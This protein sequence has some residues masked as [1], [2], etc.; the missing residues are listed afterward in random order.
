[1]SGLT[2]IECTPKEYIRSKQ[3]L[4]G[5]IVAIELLIDKM[6]LDT[7]DIA[8]GTSPDWV[9][10]AGTASYMMDDGQM[11]V[12]TQYRSLAEVAKGIAEL[13][14][15]LQMFMNQ[16]NGRAVVLRGRLNY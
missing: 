3:T 8:A 10:N 7:V 15:I 14:K 6:L 13:E 5:R 4:D 11:K 16:R 1:M 12:S 9:E 2:Y